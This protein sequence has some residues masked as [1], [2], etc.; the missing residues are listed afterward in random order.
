LS[1]FLLV[2]RVHGPCV[3]NDVP[4]LINKWPKCCQKR[5]DF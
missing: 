4:V 2:T 5:S 3:M 1:N